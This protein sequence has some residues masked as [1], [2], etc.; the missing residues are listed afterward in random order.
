[1]TSVN[2]T[3]ESEYD[4]KMASK[5]ID[6]RSIPFTLT[7]TDGKHRTTAQNRLQHMWMA[8]IAQQKGD[9]TPGEVRAYCKLTIGVPLLRDENE[10]FR[11][12]YDEVVRPLP[13]AQKMAIMMEPLDLPVTRLMTTK[14]KTEYL[15]RIFRHFGEQGIVLTIPD[16]LRYALSGA[17]PPSDAP[18]DE[19]GA[20]PALSTEAVVADPTAST[21]SD[22][23]ENPASAAGETMPTDN[24]PPVSETAVS[25]F[26]AQFR[27][28]DKE[29]GYLI[30]FCFKAMKQA[31]DT[32][33]GAPGRMFDLETMENGYR[34][35]AI[36]SEDGLKAL[37]AALV[38]I[39]AVI[40][41]K[42]NRDQAAYYIA[43]DLL[44]CNVDELR[45]LR[46][47]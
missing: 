14:Q 35:G 1:M 43:R 22:A 15:D 10:A 6:A 31:D 24:P 33:L 11:A 47:G 23:E 20:N 45:S 40:S 17:A 39:K 27:F 30:E 9:M 26:P 8:E 16:D 19:S 37:D 25:V 4:R 18:A 12:K 38:A 46:N 32:T 2:R 36:T 34:G 13:Y 5:L 44:G 42:R 29:R 3:I 21:L 7:L 28:D 41:G